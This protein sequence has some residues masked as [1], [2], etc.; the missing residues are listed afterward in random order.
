MLAI[1]E[2]FFHDNSSQVRS[3][4]SVPDTVPSASPPQSHEARALNQPLP[5]LWLREVRF[6]EVR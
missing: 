2:G 1:D 4:D 6:G 3:L 5:I